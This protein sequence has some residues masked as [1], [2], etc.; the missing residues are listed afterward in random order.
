MNFFSRKKEARVWEFSLGWAESSSMAYKASFL[1][2]PHPHGKTLR[3]SNLW[4]H[5][6]IVD[7]GPVAPEMLTRFGGRSISFQ[8]SQLSSSDT[9]QN[10][11]LWVLISQCHHKNTFLRV[12]CIEQTWVRILV[13]L[14]KT[15]LPLW[16]PPLMF[17]ELIEAWVGGEDWSHGGGREFNTSSS[18]QVPWSKP[19]LLHY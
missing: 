19:N 8:E 4:T 10:W 1:Q 2:C 11:D 7:L 3:V 17:N 5:S 12:S 13:D 6:A 14:L 16:P 15:V 9:N 18:L